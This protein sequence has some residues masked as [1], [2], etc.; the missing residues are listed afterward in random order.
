MSINI[1]A[2]EFKKLM[3]LYF[4][5]ASLGDMVKSRAQKRLI[6]SVQ[7]DSDY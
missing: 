1:F 3:T 5:I 6:S 7:C 4:S 2:I